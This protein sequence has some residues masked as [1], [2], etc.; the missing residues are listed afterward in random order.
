MNALRT[1]KS[2]TSRLPFSPRSRQSLGRLLAPTLGTLGLTALAVAGCIPG[3]FEDLRHQAP[4]VA[5]GRPAGFSRTGFG[6]NVAARV[7]G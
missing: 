1:T 5:F 2:P 7:S 6:T 4:V 3:T